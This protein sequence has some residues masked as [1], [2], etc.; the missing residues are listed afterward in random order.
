MSEIIRGTTPTVTINTDT[1]LTG[2]DTVLLTL[3]D[4]D[5]N[6]VTADKTQMTITATA[7]TAI[8]TQE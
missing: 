7:I 5:G 6:E 1:D 8:L 2:Y 4:K 3:E